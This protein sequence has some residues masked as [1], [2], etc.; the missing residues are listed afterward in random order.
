M[1]KDY[2]NLLQPSSLFN[3][4]REIGEREDIP[5]YVVGGFVR[6]ALLGKRSK[7]IDITCLGDSK[8]IAQ[9]LA[10][11]R[12]GAKV[13]H[14]K[15]FGTAMVSWQ[16]WQVEFVKA[17]KESYRPESRK[18]TVTPGTLDDDLL[19]RDSTINTLAISLN[20]RDYGTLV[21][22]CGG[23]EDLHAK[24]LKTP[25]DPN[26]TFA[27][28][29]LRMLRTVRFSVQLAFTINPITA[30][31]IT[32]EAP[33]MTILSQERIIEEFNKILLS[34]T[35]SRGI[36]LLDRYGLL[37]YILPE[38]E[39]LKGVERRGRFAHKEN[40]DHTLQVVSNVVTLLGEEPHPKRLWLLWAALLHDIAKPQTK[41]F[42]P[43]VGFTFHGHEF[44]GAKMVKPIFR[45]LRLPLGES[46]R[47]VKKLVRMHL[48]H[49]PLVEGQA[50]DSGVRRF[51]HD[52]GDDLEDLL[53]LCR[54]DITSGNRAKVARYLANFERL[55]RRIAEVQEKDNIRNLQPVIDGKEIMHT[56]N[57]KPSRVIGDLKAILKEAILEGTVPNEEGPLRAYM[58]EEAQKLGLKPAK[59]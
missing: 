24:V 47:Y 8:A 46:M 1:A 5:L 18:P 7:D 52:A 25:L 29:P 42:E 33:R 43:G 55:E 12:E 51:I 20:K 9:R 27:D 45:R 48:R 58:M 35:P 14:F 54:A 32:Q 22:R 23:L 41:R 39:A 38:M 2:S 3:T 21:D 26:I 4:L 30:Q 10:E 37:H 15:T 53:T 13:H 34:P 16:G 36:R 57:I 11:Q 6:D 56:F 40:F 17:R 31:A 59:P 44:L 19:R 49:F 50:T 28:D